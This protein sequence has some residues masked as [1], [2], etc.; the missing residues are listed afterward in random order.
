VPAGVSDELAVVS[1]VRW[2]LTKQR[3]M[4]Q[5]RQLEFYTLPNRQPMEPAKNWQYMLAT[6]SACNNHV[7]Q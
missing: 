4:D 7:K 5:Q 1:K 2:Q 3:L 6:T